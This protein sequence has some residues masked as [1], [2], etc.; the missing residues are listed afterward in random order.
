[1]LHITNNDDTYW[2]YTFQK[3]NIIARLVNNNA[4]VQYFL[5]I[6]EVH[7]QRLHYNI[8]CVHIVMT[9]M[10]IIASNA[11]IIF[12]KEMIKSDIEKTAMIKQC[13]IYGIVQIFNNI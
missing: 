13:F 1:M 9:G 7:G 10:C 8:D 11:A 6:L 2:G 3:P 12:H 5:P 4:I